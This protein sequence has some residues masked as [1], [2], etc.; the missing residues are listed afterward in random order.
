MSNRVCK[1]DQIKLIMECR[2]SGLSDYQ[3]CEQNGIHPGNFYNW[4]SKLRKNGYT[5]P[6]SEAKMNAT[7]NIQEV[8]KVDLIPESEPASSQLVEKNVSLSV[9]GAAPVVAA[10]L[11]IGNITLRLYNSADEH[12][13]QGTLR[14]IGGLNNAW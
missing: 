14:N 5:F 9:P 13:I 3:W 4:V 7:P 6:E 10:E 2:R 12:L 8:V 11:L 1:E